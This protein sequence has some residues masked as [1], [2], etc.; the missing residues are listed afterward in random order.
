[1]YGEAYIAPSSK[2]IVLIN[3]ST[4][5]VVGEIFLHLQYNENLLTLTFI[6][7]NEFMTQQVLGRIALSKLCPHWLEKFTNNLQYSSSIYELSSNTTNT[8][9][10]AKEE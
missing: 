6:N 1:M 4:L 9:T 10:N 7:I 3:G 2:Q 8:N 5:P